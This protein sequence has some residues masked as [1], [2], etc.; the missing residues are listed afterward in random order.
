MR[1]S[2]LSM[3]Y[4]SSSSIFITLTKPDSSDVEP[5][6]VDTVPL[7]SNSS[8]GSP[9]SIYDQKEKWRTHTCKYTLLQLF[10]VDAILKRLSLDLQNSSYHTQ[11]HSINYC[12]YYT[13]KFSS[14][15]SIHTTLTCINS[16]KGDWNYYEVKLY[17]KS[18]DN[19]YRQWLN[20]RIIQFLPYL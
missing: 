3:Q 5:T 2:L 8:S 16:M 11:P 20:T 13:I 9:S 10:Y 7:P 12:Y 1:S 14:N 18:A 6:I 15:S 17:F 19:R 4:L